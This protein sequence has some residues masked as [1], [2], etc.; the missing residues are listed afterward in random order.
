MRRLADTMAAEPS[1]TFQVCVD[2]ALELCGADTCGIS[3]RER[4]EGGEDV[5]RWIAMAG[6]LKHH[7][8]GTTPRYH[9]PCGIAVDKSAPV[10]MARPELFYTYLDV[11][12]PFCDVLLIPLTEKAGELEGTIW[13]VAHNPTHKFDGEDARV[14][15][16]L[17]VFVATALQRSKK[18]AE[19]AKSEAARQELVFRQLVAQRE[20][21]EAA[22]REKE[23]D[24]RL[25]LNSATDAIYC[26]DTEGV[27]T[28]CNA[29]AFCECSGINREENAI[30]R[31]L[32]DVIRIT[33][34]L[35]A[36]AIPR[37]NVRSIGPPEAVKRRM[38]T[39]SFST[40][41]TEAVSQWSTGS[42]PSCAMEH[43]R[44]RS[45]PSATSLNA[46]RPRSNRSYC[47]RELNH[48]VKNLFAVTNSIV[49]LSARSVMGPKELVA[50]ISGRLGA[51]AGALDL[52]LPRGGGRCM[53]QTSP[54]E[55][56]VSCC[57]KIFS[58]YL[59][60]PEEPG[61]VVVERPLHAYRTALRSRIFCA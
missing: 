16:R 39:T 3:L 13:V 28:K 55:L 10:L 23:A 56:N 36:G 33:A 50:S 25:V 44:A 54:L 61:R 32:H 43:Y 35:M 8:H 2:L 49:V 15:Q 9:S 38:S 22:L 21:S 46:E 40:V 41:S 30:G 12:P 1:K 51:L 27:T 52:V 6:Q 19:D 7:L 34:V 58:P 45:A 47:C 59:G 48:R 37:R 60:S 24:L 29:T 57:R 31:K 53:E 11:G 26:V 4:T 5:F 20:A 14:M 17:A 42:A 18:M